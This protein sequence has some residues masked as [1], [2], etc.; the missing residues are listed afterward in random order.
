MQPK[1][2]LTQNG[3]ELQQADINTAF[4]EASAAEDQAIQTFLRLSPF[5]GEPS[6][7]IQA[8][9]AWSPDGVNSPARMIIPYGYSGDGQSASLTGGAPNGV[10]GGAMATVTGWNGSVLVNPFRAI[11]GSRDTY[12]NIGNL[13]Q[14][15]IRTQLFVGTSGTSVG[16]VPA[17]KINLNSTTSSQWRWDLIYA[18]VTIDANASAVT[19]YVKNP[20]TLAVSA[21][22]IVTQVNTTV[23]VVYLPGTNYSS[24]AAAVQPTLP[25]DAGGVYNIPLAYI[26]VQNNWTS[27]SAPTPVAGQ[28]IYDVA[29]TPGK[30]RH[31]GINSAAPAASANEFGGEALTAYISTQG[32]AVR[33]PFY[34]PPS[35][36][37]TET[38]FLYN[39][40]GT[41][42]THG[43]KSTVDDSR[44]WMN[45]IF[46]VTAVTVTDANYSPWA[47]P[48]PGPTTV[49]PGAGGGTA[50]SACASG[51]GLGGNALA[52]FMGQSFVNDAGGASIAEIGTIAAGAS[53]VARYELDSSHW[54]SL[55]VDWADYTLKVAFT[56]GITASFFWWIEATN[57][58]PNY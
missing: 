15:D 30:Y 1:V 19:R 48:L 36:I 17:Q 35:W 51:V 34:M 56:A 57:P 58:Y 3:Q 20:S 55:Y 27:G 44:S 38:L 12:A 21:N 50:G 22:S 52:V 53:L 4:A 47:A 11:I 31:L 46:K 14:T 42:I 16:N 23:T 18:S 13:N 24:A 9:V 26:A 6:Y 8:G 7:P 40:V 5:G 29:P 39:T 32:S 2:Q 41:G 28:Y 43:S 54:V 25:A 45:R 33:P 49:T 10:I 37:G